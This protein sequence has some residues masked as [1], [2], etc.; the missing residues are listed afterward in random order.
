MMNRFRK[1]GFTLVELLV[2]IAIIGIL[3]ALLLPAV[4]AAREAAR[5]IQCSNGMRQIAL[6]MHNY[7]SSH[8]KLPP[9]QFPHMGIISNSEVGKHCWFQPLLPF[10][11]Q[12]AVYDAWR[13]Q[14]DTPAN[15]AYKGIWWTPGRW[16]PV[17]ATACPSDPVS[18]KIVTAGWSE[19]PG[20]KPENSQGFSGNVVGCAGSSR[21]AYGTRADGVAVASDGSNLDGL[22]YARSATAIRDVTDGTQH[23]LMLSEVIL[24]PD[25]MG[26]G[27]VSGGGGAIDHRGRYWNPHQGNT[28]FSTYYP[29]NSSVPDFMT[30][31]LVNANPM[32]PCA[33]DMTR[34]NQSARSYHP[35]GVN[36]TMA[37]ASVHFLSNTIDQTLYNAMGSRNGGEVLDIGGLSE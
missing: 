31:C 19:S 6:A 28:L 35:G 36:A 14:I 4:Q 34:I 1:N 7:L 21:F 22:F 8:E 5:R 32:A 3:I 11:E 15:P 25:I 27:Q 12:D 26:V 30:F 37:D 16:E 17:A 24:V 18:P 29:P 33:K 20:G 23:T 10:V 13:A 2:V 9:G